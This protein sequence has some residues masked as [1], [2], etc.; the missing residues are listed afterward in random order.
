[1][2]MASSG[3]PCRQDL[4]V[5]FI[6]TEFLRFNKELRMGRSR[7]GSSGGLDMHHCHEVLELEHGLIVTGLFK[8]IE[9]RGV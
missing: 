6:P 4:T 3:Y 5:F 1:M 2:G 8:S 7:G 9:A